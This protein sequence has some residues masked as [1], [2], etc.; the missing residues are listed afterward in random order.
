MESPYQRL[1]GDAAVRALVELFYA[2]MDSEA[3]FA[4]TRSLHP[5]SLEGLVEKL[6]FFLSG[7]PGGPAERDWPGFAYD[8]ASI[9]RS[10]AIDLNRV[11]ADAIVR[12]SR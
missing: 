4:G 12:E 8:A 5:P 7:Y 10:P 2:L 9:A 1:G 11:A 6:Y 3:E